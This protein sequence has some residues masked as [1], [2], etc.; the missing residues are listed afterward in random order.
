MTHGNIIQKEI[1]STPA[2]NSQDDIWQE[3]TG[4]E[5]QLRLRAG[6]QNQKLA[7]SSA[8]TVHFPFPS[9]MSLPVQWALLDKEE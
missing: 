3:K 8:P 5:R 6:A 1:L 4:S 9:P 7:G 2:G